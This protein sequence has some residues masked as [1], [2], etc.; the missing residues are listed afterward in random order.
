MTVFQV[1]RR[2]SGSGGTLPER[3]HDPDPRQIRSL[4]NP[5]Q[6]PARRNQFR[7]NGSG[8]SMVLDGN[9]ARLARTRRFICQR[10]LSCRLPACSGNEGQARSGPAGLAARNDFRAR[11]FPQSCLRSCRQPRHEQR[12]LR[13]AE[14]RGQVPSARG[15]HSWYPGA[16]LLVAVERY[17]ACTGPKSQRNGIVEGTRR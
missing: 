10:P 8:T 5:I 9:S 11:D 16:V 2:F 3:D 15:S 12:D 7:S 4:P 14:A 6:R 13:T 17:D 1:G